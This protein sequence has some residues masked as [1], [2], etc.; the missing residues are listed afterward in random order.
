MVLHSLCIC[1]RIWEKVPYGT[2]YV[3]VSVITTRVKS[4]EWTSG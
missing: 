2:K 3:V 1:N 4:E